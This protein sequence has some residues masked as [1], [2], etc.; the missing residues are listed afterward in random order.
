MVSVFD[1]TLVLQ[2]SSRGDLAREWPRLCSLP[3]FG[4]T[5][6]DLLEQ[7]SSKYG[8]SGIV[9]SAPQVHPSQ[10]RVAWKDDG[11]ANPIISALIEGTGKVVLQRVLFTMGL[12]GSKIR[13][14]LINQ[15]RQL[16]GCMG[17]VRRGGLLGPTLAQFAAGPF[18]RPIVVGIQG[19]DGWK[20]KMEESQTTALSSLLESYG[21][22]RA[23]KPAPFRHGHVRP[24]AL[25]APSAPDFATP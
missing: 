5:F 15:V 17:P 22:L 24:A 8:V 12:A 10:R 20:A 2:A 11:K 6:G 18:M 19:L 21:S 25:M 23:L 9:Q 3:R 7:Y 14:G 13:T 4:R 16:A 1:L